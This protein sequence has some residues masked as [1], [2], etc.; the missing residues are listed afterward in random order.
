MKAAEPTPTCPQCGSNKLYKDGLRYLADG[1]TVQR[2]LCRECGYRF[3][4]PNHKR[5]SK[6]KNPPF[7]LN[8]QNCLNDNCQG[9]NDP[10]WRDS[11]SLG[12]LVQTLATVEKEEKTK[13]GQAGATEASGKIVEFLWWLKKQGYAESTIKS[14]VKLM[15]RLVKLGA[16]LFDPDSVKEIIAKQNT[17]NPGRKE[18]AVEAYSSFLTMLG[19]TWNP[20]RYKRIPKLP[21]IPLESEIDQLI[22]CFGSKMATLLQLL[23][24][25]GIRLGEAVRIRW[26]DIDFQSGVIRITPEKGSNPRV[27]KLSGKLLQM[28]NNIRRNAETENVFPSKSCV[29]AYYYRKRKQ[30]AAKLCN[31][32]LLQISFH[33]F[34]HWKATMEYAKTKDILHVMKILGH[35]SIQNTLV[36]TQLIDFKS[37]EYVCKTAEN[38]KEAT[39]LVE[40]G[41]EYVCTTPEGIMLF[42]KRK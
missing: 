20:P 28:L 3:T 22:A 7:N 26:Q 29:E 27:L 38:A 13:S 12:R 5:R 2:W 14:R 9:N 1:T 24:E 41:F 42:R 34:R 4:N 11:T 8:L 18:L 23:K 17:W 6:W 31:P 35:K 30:I 16:N 10:E 39:Q 32:R 15:K 33:T 40:G 36:Y 37:D 25:T 21:F 19:G